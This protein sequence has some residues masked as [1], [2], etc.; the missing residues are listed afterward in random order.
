ME[1][2]FDEIERNDPKK[3]RRKSAS[4][5]DEF[6]SEQATL[7][8]PSHFLHNNDQPYSSDKLLGIIQKQVLL[9]VSNDLRRESSSIVEDYFGV[10]EPADNA[11]KHMKDNPC[12]TAN[13]DVFDISSTIYD[14]AVGSLDNSDVNLRTMTFAPSSIWEEINASINI[15]ND[16]ST[17]CVTDAS[18]ASLQRSCHPTSIASISSSLFDVPKIKSEPLDSVEAALREI[19]FSRTS[20]TVGNSPMTSANSTLPGV[21]QN[22][23]NASIF[24]SA[25][26]TNVLQQLQPSNL[27]TSMTELTC[28]L[29]SSC[30]F[31]KTQFMPM[32]VRHAIPS[33]PEHGEFASRLPPPPPYPIRIEQSLSSPRTPL[34]FNVCGYNSGQSDVTFARPRLIR[35]CTTAPTGVN[36]VRKSPSTH[37][38]CSTIRYN[39]KNNPELEKRRVHFC[40]FPGCR[41]AYTKSSHLKAHQRIHTG[42]LF[43]ID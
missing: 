38:G 26:Q 11:M 30:R 17:D 13:E 6:L 29:N 23:H 18:I 42:M 22:N 25:H 3:T 14:S 35:S 43:P 31:D 15:V 8:L 34:P 12:L 16:L 33:S 2:Y 20:M 27:S 32:N 19:T 24:N 1:K 4:V 21:F 40:V 10:S 9:D 5:V 41:K 36:R 7:T 28:P 37:P 39:R